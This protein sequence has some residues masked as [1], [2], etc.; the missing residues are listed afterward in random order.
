MRACC[1][2]LEAAVFA[3]SQAAKATSM[4]VPASSAQ[5]ASVTGTRPQAEAIRSAAKGVGHGASAGGPGTLHPSQVGRATASTTSRASHGALARRP[6]RTTSTAAAGGVTEPLHSSGGGSAR[7]LTS[8]CKP[9]R[10][11]EGFAWGWSAGKLELPKRVCAKI[12]ASQLPSH[13]V[14]HKHGASATIS[15][16]A[17]PAERPPLGDTTAAAKNGDVSAS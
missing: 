5:A 2:K 1:R 13:P 8:P 4:S 14:G 9:E 7:A 6:A 17:R 15:S 10:L 3:A 12:F 11:P 16:G